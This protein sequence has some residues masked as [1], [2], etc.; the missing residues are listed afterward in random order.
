[1]AKLRYGHQLKNGAVARVNPIAPVAGP[2]IVRGK[3]PAPSEI[4]YGPKGVQAARKA[5]FKDLA[6]MILSGRAPMK[7][8]GVR[9]WR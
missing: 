3:E 1:M 2:S 5:G 9:Q 7:S 8:G 6:D 4:D